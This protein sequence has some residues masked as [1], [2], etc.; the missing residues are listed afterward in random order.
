M[1]YKR[2]SIVERKDGMKEWLSENRKSLAWAGGAIVLVVVPL[3]LAGP[4]FTGAIAPA[5]VFCLYKAWAA[6]GDY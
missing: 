3:T 5:T 1:Q 2:R 4:V 6:Y